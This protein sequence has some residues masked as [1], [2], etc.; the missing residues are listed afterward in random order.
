MI[1]CLLSD[2]KALPTLCGRP[3]GALNHSQTHSLASLTKENL[4]RGEL[5][6]DFH[7]RKYNVISWN[8]NEQ[9]RKFVKI[10]I[11]YPEYA[12]G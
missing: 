7:H 5:P 9:D 11:K 3:I 10:I 2:E 6:F 8:H 4:L 12:K 1:H